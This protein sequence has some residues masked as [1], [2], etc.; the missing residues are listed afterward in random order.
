MKIGIDTF[1]CEHG[2]S[3]LGSYLL[4]F[5][6]NIPDDTNNE[7]ELFGSEIDRY[8]YSQ[9]KKFSYVSVNVSDN[10][11]SE[12]IWHHVR[13]SKFVKKQKY[14]VVIIPAVERVFPRKVNKKAVIILNTVLSSVLTEC[15]RF[16]RKRLIKALEK[17]GMI[18]A[19]SEFIRKDLVTNGID[20][21]KIKVVYAGIDSRIFFPILNFDS[22]V[23]QVKPFSFKRPYFIFCSKIS[24]EEKRHI[25]LIKAFTLFKE[26]TNLPHRLIL[27]GTESDYAEKVHKEA[28]ESSAASDIFFTGFFPMES[29]PA[30]YSGAD[31]CVFPAENEGLGLPVLESMGCGIPVLCARSGALPEIGGGTPLYFDSSNID[32]IATNLEKIVTDNSLRE[33]MITSGLEHVK[34]FTW[35]ECVNQIMNI[36]DSENK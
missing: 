26:R 5:I 22:D 36:I 17:S 18:I 27:A 25:E 4:N 11:E 7:I 12:K 3:G 34:K 16:E 14:D 9:K 23:V 20:K 8:T 6:S 32:E 35:S 29:L 19:G 21:K 31:A 10:I 13:F 28:F 2:K 33:K 1:G 15:D 24:G 30:L